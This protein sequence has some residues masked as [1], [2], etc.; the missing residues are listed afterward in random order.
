[1]AAGSV[2]R[3]LIP[4]HKGGGALAPVWQKS[5]DSVNDRVCQNTKNNGHGEETYGKASHIQGDS[6]DGFFHVHDMQDRI[7]AF[8]SY[9]VAQTLLR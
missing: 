1:M 8:G 6:E 5:G 9:P 4:P 7:V 2:R 3:L